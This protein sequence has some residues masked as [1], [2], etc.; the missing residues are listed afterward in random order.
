MNKLSTFSFA[1]RIRSFSYALSGIAVLLKS[2]HNAWIHLVATT[3]VISGGLFFQ[4]DPIEW[5]LVILAILAVF[6]AEALNTAI[7]FLCDAVSPTPHPLIQKSKDVAAG[8]VLISAIGA[9]V[10]GLIIFP[11]YFKAYL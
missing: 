8:A 6:V 5:C 7:E 10:I 11:P 4:I 1:A 3:L 2:Q 9:I